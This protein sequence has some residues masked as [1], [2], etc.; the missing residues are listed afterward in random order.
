MVEE[1][2]ITLISP[3]ALQHIIDKNPRRP[4]NETLIDFC[5]TYDCIDR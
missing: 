5:K 1:H 2:L 3:V 4:L